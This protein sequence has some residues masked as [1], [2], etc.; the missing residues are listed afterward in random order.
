MGDLLVITSL[1]DICLAKLFP[2]TTAAVVHKACPL[3]PEIQKYYFH[4]NE[5]KI[6]KT[7]TVIDQMFHAGLLLWWLMI[8]HQNLNMPDF[9]SDP[10][11]SAFKYK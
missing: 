2:P 1:S 5:R 4:N 11:Y 8:Q 6:F 10:Q 9:P 7:C 3:K